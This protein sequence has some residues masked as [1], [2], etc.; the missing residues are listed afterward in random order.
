MDSTQALKLLDTLAN[1]IDPFTGK[2]FPA[3][4][5]YQHPEVVRALC[6]AVRLLAPPTPRPQRTDAATPGASAAK[7]APRASG[8]PAKS[9]KPWSQ[10]EDEQLLAGYDAGQTIEALARS[11][12][13]SRLGVEARLAKFGRVPMPAGVRGL[14]SSGNAGQPAAD[15][16][17]DHAAT[18]GVRDAAQP[19]Y[20]VHH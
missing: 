13:R 3:D 16:A 2:Q 12:E 7:T 15:A 1:G 11:F 19:I 9:G 17:A 4:S 18:P 6:H 10:S 5:P 20:R 8:R 14:N